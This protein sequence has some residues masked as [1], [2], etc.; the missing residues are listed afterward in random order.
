[1]KKI[2]LSATLA[3]LAVAASAQVGNRRPIN[4]R[5]ETQHNRIQQGVK[6][7]SLSRYEAARIRAR[8]AAIRAR[9]RR[10]RRD[11]HGLSRAERIR[12]QRA[13]NRTSRSIYRQ[14]HD[15]QHRGH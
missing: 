9:E 11:G 7:G 14:K 4:H 8:E 3:L 5:Q 10:D 12:I 2:F 15:R 1:M 6:R 13:Q